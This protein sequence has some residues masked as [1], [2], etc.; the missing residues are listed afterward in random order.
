MN[1]AL[2]DSERLGGACGASAQRTASC[3]YSFAGRAA[4]RFTLKK[5][6]PGHQASGVNP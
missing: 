1:V 4:L 6:Q 5:A 2:E 3:A